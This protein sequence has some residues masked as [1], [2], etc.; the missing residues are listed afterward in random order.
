M[1]VH[2]VT[3]SKVSTTIV[4]AALAWPRPGNGGEVV[5]KD[6]PLVGGN[7]I[8]SVVETLRRGRAHRI[9]RQHL[10]GNKP[11]VEAIADSVGG[12]GGDY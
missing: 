11:T 5:S 10:S 3:E 6:Y 9:E 2:W 1:A 4:V 8:A 7:K 12:N